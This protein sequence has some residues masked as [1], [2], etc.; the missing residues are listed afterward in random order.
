MTSPSH[1]VKSYAE[2]VKTDKEKVIHEDEGLIP[3]DISNRYETSLLEERRKFIL[4]F[5]KFMRNNGISKFWK[6]GEYLFEETWKVID[7]MP[8]FLQEEYKSSLIDLQLLIH[9]N[10]AKNHH[11]KTP[12]MHRLNDLIIE[13]EEANKNR[14][15]KNLNALLSS[16]K[17]A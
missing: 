10:F 11:F 3:R 15:E 8:S 7:M 1:E 14:G 9:L 13:F 6:G 16:S 5:F 17:K 2:I 12:Y 4:Q